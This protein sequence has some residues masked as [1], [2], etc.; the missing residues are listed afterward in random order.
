M[1]RELIL[2]EAAGNRFVKPQ[3]GA[4]PEAIRNAE[5][6]LGCTFPRELKD[7][8]LEMNGDNWRLYSVSDILERNREIRRLLGEEREG[9]DSLL[10]F[11]GNGC[12]GYYCYELL[13]GGR[14]KPG[15]IFLWSRG[16]SAWRPA[17]GSI[18]EL[19][20]RYYRDGK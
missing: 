14:A 11:A 10:F 12:G 8:L 2:R 17:A 20:T 18:A 19:I 3:A 16:N 1:Y 7:M 9:L 6:L 5:H 4:D 13:P 15:E